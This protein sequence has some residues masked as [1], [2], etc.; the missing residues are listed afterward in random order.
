MLFRTT[1][2]S[3][4]WLAAD[5]A[6]VNIGRQQ[7]V[8]L[9]QNKRFLDLFGPVGSDTVEARRH[10][11]PIAAEI[12]VHE[13]GPVAEPPQRVAEDRRLLARL[14]DAQI[15]LLVVEAS[16]LL[17]V[18]RGRAHEDG[19]GNPPGRGVSVQ[20]GGR[21]ID[22]VGDRLRAVDIASDDR[23]PTYLE[24]VKQLR[25]YARRTDRYAPRHDHHRGI[26]VHPQFVNGLGHQPQ[27]AARALKSF[28]RAPARIELIEEFRMDGVSFLKFAPVIFIGR[29]ARKLVC[30]FPIE[31]G[32]SRTRFPWTQNWL[33]RSVQGGPEHDR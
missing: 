15:D 26:V 30:V 10:G 23:L 19:A 17:L 16:I 14:H 9:H 20:I 12:A 8:D 2:I 32:V 21:L 4:E 5:T 27:H 3:T 24:I 13:P 7:L 22:F 33:N 29:A 6:P 28:Q 11:V 25:F 18:R 1:K 31:L